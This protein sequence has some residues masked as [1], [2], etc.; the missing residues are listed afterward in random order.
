VVDKVYAGEWQIFCVTSYYCEGSGGLCLRVKRTY[1]DRCWYEFLPEYHKEYCEH[2][3]TTYDTVG[4]CDYCECYSQK[5]D[6]QGCT[7]AAC[8]EGQSE[9]NY[10][11]L[12]VGVKNSCTGENGC[13]ACTI[14]RQCHYIE[15]NEEP[16]EPSG[17]EICYYEGDTNPEFPDWSN[18]DSES[19]DAIS[20]NPNSPTIVRDNYSDYDSI[21]I[22][23]AITEEP[24]GSNT[25]GVRYKV[26]VGGLTSGWQLLPY[27]KVINV[28]E[29]TPAEEYGAQQIEGD[30]DMGDG[31][32]GAIVVTADTNINTTNK[33][34]GR[35]C[36]QGGDAVNYSVT[37]LSSNAATLS[38]EPSGGCLSAGDEVILINIGGSMD[39]VVNV[40]NYEIFEVLDISGRNVYF[41]SNKTKYYGEG[42]SDDN[43]IGTADDTQKVMLQR[44]PHYTNVTVNS[45]AEFYPTSYNG[46]LGGVMF[47]R[48]TGT[49]MVNGSIDASGS[50]YPG[51][52]KANDY[53]YNAHA[54]WGLFHSGV[55]L[56]GA[57]GRPVYE[58]NGSGHNGTFSGG[59]G[60]SVNYSRSRG[61]GIS[62]AGVGSYISG[63]V[64]G[65]GGAS[66]GTDS[67]GGGGGG[68]G[69]ITPGE[70]GGGNTKAEDGSAIK[71]G[72]GTRTGG[73]TGDWDGG[74]GGGGTSFGSS[75]YE[76]LIMG[77]GGGGGGAGEAVIGSTGR[78]YVSGGEG[79]GGGGVMMVYANDLRINGLLKADG[80]DGGEPIRN[81]TGELYSYGGG[82]GGG[83]GGTLLVE[84]N[85]LYIGGTGLSASGG[86]G[87]DYA[88][89][90]GG[91]GGDGVSNV[92]YTTLLVDNRRNWTSLEYDWNSSS[93]PDY[94]GELIDGFSK[95]SASAG[96][97][98]FL[99]EYVINAEPGDID[100]NIPQFKT[101]LESEAVVEI[102]YQAGTIDR[103]DYD[104]QE[105]EVLSG[106]LSLL[107]EAE[108][109]PQ[110]QPVD[111][112][113]DPGDDPID[114]ENPEDWEDWIGS[115]ENEEFHGVD[116]SNNPI[117]FGVKMTH[118][119][120]IDK[121][122]QVRFDVTA[123]PSDIQEEDL[124][125]VLSI[126]GSEYSLGYVEG[127]SDEIKSE[128]TLDKDED[129]YYLREDIVRTDDNEFIVNKDDTAVRVTSDEIY[130]YVDI[131]FIGDND[132]TTGNNNLWEGVQTV[133]WTGR[134]IE[135]VYSTIGS[136]VTRDD[137]ITY[138]DSGALN[139]DFT[140]P[141][142]LHDFDMESCGTLGILESC[143][144]MD[145]TEPEEYDSGLYYL[146]NPSY[147]LWPDDITYLLDDVDLS[148]EDPRLYEYSTS[149][150]ITKDNEEQA[151]GVWID[152]VVDR[153]GNI[154]TGE[155]LGIV[156]EPER[157]SWIRTDGGD[158][159]AAEGYSNNILAEYPLGKS[160]MSQYW[161]G[162][163]G[164][165][166]VFDFSPGVASLKRWISSR[167][168]DANSYG[169]YGTLRRIAASSECAEDLGAGDT[170]EYATGTVVANAI[171]NDRG[172]YMINLSGAD[173]N[174]ETLPSDS[175]CTG[176]D[177]VIFIS[178][179]DLE[180]SPNFTSS[181]G[182]QCLFVTEGDVTILG[183]S[184]AGGT[185]DR[186]VDPA[187][188]VTDVYDQ[189]DASF[190]VDGTF[191][192]VDDGD[193]RLEIN[194]SVFAVETAF[195]RGL[196]LVANRVLPSEYINYT[197]LYVVFEDMLGHRSF[198]QFECG[199]VEDSDVCDGWE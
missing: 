54:G 18:G 43:N 101:G 171:D 111:P 81:K 32:D 7:P 93:N 95:S 96:I 75:N 100:V 12:C 188:I 107:G 88:V 112:P 148:E 128:V 22:K 13:N 2:A 60:G 11:D 133:L 6:C 48:A 199:V 136:S 86:Q 163:G 113:D 154:I 122:D 59:G 92:Y 70:G 98:S 124:R 167:Y 152:N 104:I 102:N 169:W 4:S 193:E 33:I 45:G 142:V 30:I 94:L 64:G 156:W 58:N 151:A 164:S 158:V 19:C 182:S 162:G 20:T 172:I 31:S 139:I 9:V 132:G 192:T 63:A 184:V 165:Q 23:S 197:P 103:C 8:P 189:V 119:E 69:H 191:T 89:H 195:D 161:L 78:D 77:G 110:P 56:D 71:S 87:G 44:V 129:I 39:S 46:T 118:P 149:I 146:E 177:K 198:R 117:S 25:Q 157:Y 37:A 186:S 183:G 41:T 26:G 194:G 160:Y 175:Q 196:P 76:K 141:V 15:T 140:P 150:K 49:V 52:A 67:R 50:G 134:D 29:T 105:G 80:E 21:F 131:T 137:G 153:V 135:G 170:C 62:S 180:V 125:L 176:G 51:G 3:Y 85:I 24:A 126:D 127:L 166:L 17:L 179:G 47:F 65:G 72:D 35:S 174:T 5:Y 68:G 99:N 121:I 97:Y 14:S 1:C 79:G 120:G 40:G 145:I 83:G 34:S 190:I 27:F 159:Y 90:D 66:E 181:D 28:D 91:D 144:V 185:V 36:S 84:S 16:P 106:Y 143:W 114:I 108:P 116:L 187:V 61:Y 42:L 138:R 130:V 168:Q 38:V 147:K 57:G 178:N 53:T 55:I 82:G 115:F 123:T 74:G 173:G 10:G 155:D 73:P 109:G